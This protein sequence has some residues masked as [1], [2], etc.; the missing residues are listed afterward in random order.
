MTRPY[1]PRCKTPADEIRSLEP[2]SE[3]G[4]GDVEVTSWEPRCGCNAGIMMPDMSEKVVLYRPEHGPLAQL[5]K[6]AK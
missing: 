5:T 4:V 3:C 2:C 1:C 6:E